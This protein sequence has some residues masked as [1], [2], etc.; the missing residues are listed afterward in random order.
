MEVQ[1]NE[2]RLKK[3]TI[4][5]LVQTSPDKISLTEKQLDYLFNLTLKSL[6]Q[7]ISREQFIA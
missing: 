4:A 7:S 3:I 6:Q 5:R 2:A 1:K